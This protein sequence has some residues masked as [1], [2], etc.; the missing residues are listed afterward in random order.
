M[1]PHRSISHCASSATVL[2]LPVPRARLAPPLA[3]NVGN[4]PERAAATAACAWA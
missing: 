3:P 4:N 1:R 2:R